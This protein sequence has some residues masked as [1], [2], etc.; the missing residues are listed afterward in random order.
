MEEPRKRGRPPK[1]KSIEGSPKAPSK[2]LMKKWKGSGAPLAQMR[3]I[4]RIRDKLSSRKKEK[5]GAETN[6]V[7]T[8]EKDSSVQS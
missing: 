1:S 6:S 4:S 5:D 8:H 7:E 2:H 3:L